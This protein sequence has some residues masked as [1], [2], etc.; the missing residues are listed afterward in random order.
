MRPL[1]STCSLVVDPPVYIVV[2]G[3]ELIAVLL[4]DLALQ[5]AFLWNPIV[6]IFSLVL[7]GWSVALVGVSGEAAFGPLV[8][9]FSVLIAIPHFG[10]WPSHSNWL[11]IVL[12]FD[13]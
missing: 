13:S 10:G 11:G 3:F 9:A 1:D 5:V 4:P 6:T 7:S 2:R 12:V 8:P